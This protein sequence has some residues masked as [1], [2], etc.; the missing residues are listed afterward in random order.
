[1]L[2]FLVNN[3][4]MLFCALF[5]Y[6]L[7]KKE[8]TAICGTQ[9]TFHTPH[10]HH[11]SLSLWSRSCT[12]CFLL[13]LS[14]W[15]PAVWSVTSCLQSQRWPPCCR[16]QVTSGTAYWLLN[17]TPPSDTETR[18]TL[19][20]LFLLQWWGTILLK[21]TL[22]NINNS[23]LSIDFRIMTPLLRRWM[24]TLQTL[25]AVIST[26]SHWQEDSFCHTVHPPLQAD[27]EWA[28]SETKM[29]GHH[30]E[31]SSLKSYIEVLTGPFSWVASKFYSVIISGLE[32]S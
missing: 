4:F 26:A 31:A 28:R 29:V 27:P 2:V 32:G 5:N 18:C 3:M 13:F 23:Y 22:L 15:S 12:C 16:A 25:R 6:C 1:M 7:W 17:G 21:E 11:T 10:Q 30:T 8:H 14:A 19:L 20:L 9:W 24:P